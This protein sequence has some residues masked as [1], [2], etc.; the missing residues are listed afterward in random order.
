MLVAL[1]DVSRTLSHPYCCS[2]CA[3]S[4]ERICARGAVSCHPTRAYPGVPILALLTPSYLVL[5]WLLLPCYDVGWGRTVRQGRMWCHPTISYLVVPIRAHRTT[6]YLVLNWSLLP[7][8][9]VL[10]HPTQSYQSYPI[11]PCL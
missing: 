1:C 9:P 3:R 11:L 4:Y 8:Y 2:N 7:C 5:Y 6:A 10:P